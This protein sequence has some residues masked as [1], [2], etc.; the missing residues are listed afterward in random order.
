M[1]RNSIT[2]RLAAYPTPLSRACLR[3]LAAADS[4]ARSR[5]RRD[6]ARGALAILGAL[7]AGILKD[8]KRKLPGVQPLQPGDWATAKAL[9]RLWSA[10][11]PA[12]EAEI[13]QGLEPTTAWRQQTSGWGKG[14]AGDLFDLLEAISAPGNCRGTLKPEAD[15]EVSNH[16][17]VS[18]DQ[19][20]NF[21]LDGPLAFLTHWTMVAVTEV[22][23]RP[24]GQV[25]FCT[26][27]TGPGP[28]PNEITFPN[29]SRPPDPGEVYLVDRQW[30]WVS[31]HPFVIFLQ[32]CPPVVPAEAD[33]GHDVFYLDSFGASRAEMRSSSYGFVLAQ[34]HLTREIRAA[35]QGLASAAYPD[36]T[37]P[38]WGFAFIEMA[39]TAAANLSLG[40]EATDAVLHAIDQEAALL[41]GEDLD[42]KGGP[43]LFPFWYKPDLLIMPLAYDEKLHPPEMVAGRAEE[44]LRQLLVRA[45]EAAVQAGL[46]PIFYLAI[47]LVAGGGQD[48]RGGGRSEVAFLREVEAS[49]EA[50]RQAHARAPEARALG[51]VWLRRTQRSSGFSYRVEGAYTR[52]SQASF[53]LISRTTGN[54]IEFLLRFNPRHQAFNF[55]GGHLEEADQG[56]P[57]ATLTREIGEELGLAESDYRFSRLW[58]D[59][60]CAV[61]FSEPYDSWTYYIH[62]F[63][64]VE[65]SQSLTPDQLRSSQELVWASL[66]ELTSGRLAD[67]RPISRF[68]LRLLAPILPKLASG[69]PGKTSPVNDYGWR[70]LVSANRA[71]EMTGSG[72]STQV[73]AT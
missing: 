34:N 14:A 29:G 32:I 9:R 41:A 53:A 43:Q 7:G 57:T 72:R 56:D 48:Q 45:Q 23:Q 1:E 33:F 16:G 51:Q 27:L 26:E 69:G 60:L 66:D 19:E 46:S 59:A 20:V 65:L 54:D 5:A 44:A 55:V 35:W 18:P 49:R 30:R 71:P 4:P 31:L 25:I 64:R 73:D 12:L 15:R 70:H 68:P 11:G 50:V 3:Y 52:I 37:R 2:A 22:H 13:A 40:Y 38:R 21:L 63:F 61:E 17:F 36:W 62:H 8:L 10:A 58:E 6:L 28:W 24:E 67:G 42:F 47:D 39:Y